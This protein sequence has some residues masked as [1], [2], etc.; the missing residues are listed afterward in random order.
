MSNVKVDSAPSKRGI[1]IWGALL[2]LLVIMFVSLGALGFVLYRTASE[3]AK[4]EKQMLAWEAEKAKGEIDRQKAAEEAKLAMARAR[5]V[6]CLAQVRNATNALARLLRDLDFAKDQSSLLRT[7]D[8][9]RKIAQYPDLL[10]L[11]RRLYETDLPELPQR[12]VVI[13]KLEGE[14][15]FEQQLVSAAGTAYEP[16][17]SFL[18]TA[19]ADAVWGIQEGAK[20]D[21]ARAVII[22]LTEEVRVK[23]SPPS[24]PGSELSLQEAIADFSKKEIVLRQRILANNEA[25][26]KTKA[27]ETLAAAEGERILQEAKLKADKI[28][29]EANLRVERHN[30]DKKAAAE[31]AMTEARKEEL[32]KKAR[33]IWVKAK[34]APFTTP[35][36][37][38]IEAPDSYEKKPLSFSAL[39]QGGA[40]D[41]NEEGIRKLA[42]V[43]FTKEDK[44]RPRFIFRQ[45]SSGSWMRHTEDRE[46]VMEAQKLLLEL[47][48]VLVDMGLMQP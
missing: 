39:Y 47:G 37:A 44:V 22:T 30:A 26:A 34:L 38:Q 29:Q 32:R 18:S 10:V 21:R 4:L 11:A 23:V 8:L 46:M 28:L 16:D 24:S 17:A 5:Q 43:G 25:E 31:S 3:K 41:P 40:L 36:Y 13:A 48:P 35:G 20:V 14:R 12:E 1:P 15:R 45:N 19:Q 33:S 2:F 6:E 9:G 42:W 27:A 7:N